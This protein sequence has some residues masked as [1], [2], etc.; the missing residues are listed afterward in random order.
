RTFRSTGLASARRPSPS[1]P[2]CT[3]AG[4]TDLRESVG[5]AKRSAPARLF[6]ASPYAR[7]A[8]L[9]PPDA[10]PCPKIQIA[11]E[12][13]NPAPPGARFPSADGLSLFVRD[14]GNRLSPWLPVVCLPGLSRSGRDFDELAVALADD[15]LRPRRVLAFDYRGRGQSEWDRTSDN[16]NPLV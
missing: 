4:C 12:Y 3:A 2:T 16:Y 5:W 11:M 13:E 9:C 7:D 6:A 15:S 1:K 14:Y 10:S 8:S